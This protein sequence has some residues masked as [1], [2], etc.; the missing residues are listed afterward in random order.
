M[1]IANF[2]SGNDEIENQLKRDR[3]MAKNEIKMLLL[4]AGESGKV[5]SITSLLARLHNWLRSPS[6]LSS[7]KWNWFTTVDITSKNENPIRKSFSLTLFSLC[8]VYFLS[9]LKGFSFSNK[10]CYSG[11]LAS[12]PIGSAPS[13][14]SSTLSDLWYIY[15]NFLLFCRA[16]LE[17]LP[18]LDLQLEPSNDARRNVVLSLPGQ[19]ETDYLPRDVADSIRGLWA[20]PAIREAV[21]RSRE[22]QLNDSAV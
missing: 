21:R 19:I 2:H 1:H 18:Q 16:I 6:R 20:D 4:G 9:A 8:G 22:F 10:N 11:S 3:M 7:S 5:F 12:C 15:K 14:F 13:F 17:A